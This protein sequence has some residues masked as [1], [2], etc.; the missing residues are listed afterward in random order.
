LGLEL[1]REEGKTVDRDGD[2]SLMRTEM[3]KGGWRMRS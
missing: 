2:E 1:G 3:K